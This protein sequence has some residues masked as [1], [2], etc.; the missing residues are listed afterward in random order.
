MPCRLEIKLVEHIMKFIREVMYAQVTENINTGVFLNN[1]K[2]LYFLFVGNLITSAKHYGIRER[3]E[4]K[5][6]KLSHL[7]VVDHMDPAQ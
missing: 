2:P 5:L 4:Q 6:R 3:S 1:S 7:I